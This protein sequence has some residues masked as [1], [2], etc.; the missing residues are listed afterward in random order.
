MLK[1]THILGFLEAIYDWN[2]EEQPHFDLLFHRVP[3]RSDW[4]VNIHC[5]KPGQG[6][7]LASSTSIQLILLWTPDA[8]MVLGIF[9]YVRC[10]T[11]D[12]SHNQ[13]L[14]IVLKVSVMTLQYGSIDYDY[15]LWS[16]MNLMLWVMGVIM[17]MLFCS[18]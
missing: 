6:Y 18:D 12:I 2:P 11:G 9:H 16:K 17:S 14:T 15:I 7:I 1:W 10:A 5:T 4:C 3:L 13:R 8:I